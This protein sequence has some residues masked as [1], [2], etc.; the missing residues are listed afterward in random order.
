MKSLLTMSICVV[1][2]AAVIS[3]CGGGSGAADGS[4]RVGHDGGDDGTAAL[5]PPSGGLVAEPQ[6][7]QLVVGES[8]SFEQL[9]YALAVARCSY[10]SRCF[11]LATYVANQCVDTAIS[12]GIWS[13]LICEGDSSESTC[14]GSTIF[15]NSGSRAQLL[16]AASA[17]LVHYDPQRAS[18]CIAAL[19]T[20]GCV[21]KQLVEAIP[22]CA[23][24][25]SCPSDAGAAT[26]GLT[27]G[28][29]YGDASDAGSSDAGS[30]DAGASCSTLLGAFMPF[31]ICST[32]DECAGTVYPEGPH[33]V[34]G[35]CSP[36]LCGFSR[37]CTIF[38][39]AGQPCDAN[40]SSILTTNVESP[41]GT[42]APGLACR[43]ATA[44]AGPGTCITPQDVGAPCALK[45]DCKS[46]LAC[47]CGVCEIP[48]RTGPCADGLCQIGVAY[49]DFGT[50]TCKPVLQS[51]D[52][53]VG[54]NSCAPG[55][56]CDATICMPPSL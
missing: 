49:C 53:C 38:A 28:A 37:E 32:D 51:G 7:R 36:S 21:D 4:P 41:T 43:R 6:A 22:A 33:C 35:F 9:P 46:G 3:S 47:A 1:G 55:L 18:Q 39:E 10:W 45:G 5:C 25:F 31:A 19:L 48:P 15:F 26:S 52:R 13:Y 23:G 14:T 42:C 20:E 17:G 27:D 11:G 24:M 34:D 12:A 8:V 29:S 30:S 40:A 50:G 56:I 2:A 54:L 16:P 44:D